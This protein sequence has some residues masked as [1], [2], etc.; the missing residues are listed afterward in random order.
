MESMEITESMESPQSEGTE[1][2]TP[3]ELLPAAPEMPEASAEDARL[4]ALLEAVVYVTEEPLS[5][6][7]LAN[8]I[9]APRE[10]VQALLEQ[11]VAEF[12]KPEHGVTIRV[13]AEGYKMA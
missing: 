2:M 8:G 7:Q 6:E 12:D 4:K 3:E 5:L 11:L 9:G 13:V 1:T 10:R